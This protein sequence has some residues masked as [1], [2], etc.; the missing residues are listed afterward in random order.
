MARVH[1]WELSNYNN[2]TLIGKWFDLDGYTHDEHRTEVKEWL[3]EL[4][5]KTG[6]LCEEWIVG[7][8]EEIPENFVG[9]YSLDS[10]FFDYMEALNDSGLDP[11]VFEAGAYLD[12]PYSEIAENYEGYHKSDSDFAY[13]LVESIGF[14]SDVPE[15]IKQYFDYDKFATDLMCSDYTEHNG[16]YFLR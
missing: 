16:H 4:T 6:A 15:N 3:A 7:D 10:D 14:L 8:Y 12:I 1:Y 9:T 13:E 5:E 2:G 11:E